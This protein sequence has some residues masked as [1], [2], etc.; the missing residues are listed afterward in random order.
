MG[1]GGW[2]SEVSEQYRQTVLRDALLDVKNCDHFCEVWRLMVWKEECQYLRNVKFI[3]SEQVLS[4]MQA[5]TS[6]WS[7]THL[8][9]FTSHSNTLPAMSSIKYGP[10]IFKHFSI[11]SSNTSTS[12]FLNNV[13]STSLALCENSCSST[14]ENV[15]FNCTSCANAFCE[16]A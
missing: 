15:E 8:N 6:V 11:A 2:G 3:D 10:S 9:L 12:G 16:S 4:N 1:T 14:S 5:N 7:W 13:L